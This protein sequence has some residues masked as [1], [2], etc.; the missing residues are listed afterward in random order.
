MI[1]LLSVFITHKRPINRF[2]RYDIFKYTLNSYKHI[3]FSEM[4]LFILLDDEF[5]NYKD[6]LTQFIKDTFTLEQNKIHITFD[7]YYKQIQWIPFIDELMKNHG[8]NE[9]VWFTQNDDHVFVDFNMDILEEGLELLKEEPNEHKSLYFSHWPEQIKMCG[10]YNNHIRVN[11]YV[12]Y[13]LSLLDSIQIFGL[14]FL[15]DIFVK[16]QW[17]KDHTRIDSVL[18]ELTNNPSVEDP[19]KQTIYIPLRELCRHFDGYDHVGMNPNDCGPLVLPINTFKYDQ[20]SLI[21][22]MT[23][24]HNS[25][26]TNNNFF[27]IPHEWI[28]INIKLHN[29]LEY[30]L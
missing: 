1:F 10:K 5:L 9:L 24:P 16:Y 4:Y 25:C 23:A 13:N 26:W 22:K 3:P 18:N 11:N 17:K 19:L 21:K 15:Y 7:R 28:D 29:K 27:K 20:I 12:K 30:S 2:S 14:K 8:G 6:E